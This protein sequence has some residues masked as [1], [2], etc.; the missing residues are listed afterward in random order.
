MRNQ[1]RI[2]A[3][4][5]ALASALGVMRST[6]GLAQFK[7]GI[8]MVLLTVTVTDRAG[9][10]V[11]GLTPAAFTI[12]EDG[13]PQT[14][15]YFA[16][17]D[18]PVDLAL[19]LDNSS[20]MQ[21]DFR[22][23]QDAAC[24]LT[25]QLRSGDRV[26]LS[27]I[28]SHTFNAQTLTAD[29]GRVEQAIRSMEAFGPTAIYE[30]V[31]VLFRELQR[32]PGGA[33]EARRRA[34]VL[35]SD[36]L[37]NASRVEFD[38]VLDSVRRGDIV[39]YV[40]LLDR[41]LKG[42]MDREESGEALRARF[43]MGSLARESGGRIFTPQAASELPGIYDTVARELRNQYLLGYSPKRQEGDGSFR[44]ITVGVQHPDAVRARTRAG[45]FAVAPRATRASR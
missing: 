27:G 34:I 21:V 3:L 38:H 10:Y 23:A 31:Y 20:S 35:L 33:S 14:L 15:S 4:A 12:F 39:V 1:T 37:D 25:R 6:P 22:L 42:Q 29:L 44:R 8:Q 43:A 24:G 9:H 28:A 7:S 13:Q 16:A 40:V 19:L 5:V 17:V 26:A 41:S 2:A 32:G 45:Y 30:G 36:G 18:A 11:P